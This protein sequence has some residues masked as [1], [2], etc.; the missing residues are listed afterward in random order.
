MAG[1]ASCAKRL[2][3]AW[4][5]MPVCSRS[6]AA[7]RRPCWR[8]SP[9]GLARSCQSDRYAASWRAMSEPRYWE[10]YEVGQKYSL[11]STSFTAEEIVEF[12]RQFDPQPFHVDAD[13]AKASMFG[14][15]I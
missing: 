1:W 3:N 6:A 11:G 13:A 2:S 5:A 4:R 10:D 8:R 7:P 9:S 12:A 15:L 14:G